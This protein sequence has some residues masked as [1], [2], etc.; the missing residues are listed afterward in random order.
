MYTLKFTTAPAFQTSKCAID[1]R[2][3]Q[4]TPARTA[5]VIKRQSRRLWTLVPAASSRNM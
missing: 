3:F 2:Y 5:S 4:A 1:Y